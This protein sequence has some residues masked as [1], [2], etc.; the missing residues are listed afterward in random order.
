MVVSMY[1][2]REEGHKYRGVIYI[3][4]YICIYTY[5]YMCIYTYLSISIYPYIHIHIPIHIHVYIYNIGH[6]TLFFLLYRWLEVHVWR[7]QGQKYRGVIYIYIYTYIHLSISI[8]I[9]LYIDT[10]IHHIGFTPFHIF[11]CLLHRWLEVDVWRE[12]GQEYRGDRCGVL[13]S[14]R[15]AIQTKRGDGSG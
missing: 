10:S 13:F 11:F 1:V 6:T 2:R 3:Y 5:V 8:C 4:I 9:Y 7:E 14:R 15:E 12:E